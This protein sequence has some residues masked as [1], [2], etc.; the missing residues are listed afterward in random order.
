MEFKKNDKAFLIENNIRVT[1]VSI[2]RKDGYNYLVK[3]P[4]GG[5]LRVSGKRLYASLEEAEKCLPYRNK[6]DEEKRT[7][8]PA[9]E[10]MSLEEEEVSHSPHY[11]GWI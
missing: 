10:K 8:K 4:S 9:Y 1:E 2:I 6:Q 7:E 5:G 3:L 11:L